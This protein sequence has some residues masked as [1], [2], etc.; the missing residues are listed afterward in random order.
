MLVSHD[1]SEIASCYVVKQ[2]LCI[3]RYVEHAMLHG[4]NVQIVATHVVLVNVRIQQFGYERGTG[5]SRIAAA[6]ERFLGKANERE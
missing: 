1:S 2:L 5:G 3:V 4:C 6:V